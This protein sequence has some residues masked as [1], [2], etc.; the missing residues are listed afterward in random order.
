MDSCVVDLSFKDNTVFVDGQRRAA[1]DR[2]TRV[3]PVTE[4][5]SGAVAIR[6]AAL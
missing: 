2:F 3:D 6:V 1:L 5:F 4:P